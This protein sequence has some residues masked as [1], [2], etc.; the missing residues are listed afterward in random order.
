[1]PTESYADLRLP[2]GTIASPAVQIGSVGYGLWQNQSPAALGLIAAGIEAVRVGGALLEIGTVTKFHTLD[3]LGA[4]ETSDGLFVRELTTNLAKRVSLT[5]PLSISSGSLVADCYSKSAGDARYAAIAH[6]HAWADIT[7]KPST[8]TPSAHQSS[9]QSGGGDA[10]SGL[11][12]ATARVLVRRNTGTNVGPRR[13]LNF[14]EG[15]N[16]TLT[17]TDDSA[18]EEVDV[19]IA[20]TPGGGGGN[21]STTGGAAG[22]VARF[23]GTNDI[24]NARIADTL[25]GPIVFGAAVSIPGATLT[26]QAPATAGAYIGVFTSDPTTSGAAL[27]SRTLALFKG[28]LGTMPPSAHTHLWADITDKPATFPPSTH[29]HAWADITGKPSTFAPSAHQSSHQSGGGD[30]LTGLL[31]ATARVLVRRNTGTNVG[32][33]RRLNFIEGSNVTLTVAADSGQEE[34]KVTIAAAT[35]GG[36]GFVL[37][38]ARFQ[39]KNP[40]ADGVTIVGSAGNATNRFIPTTGSGTLFFTRDATVRS[41]AVYK[42]VFT[43]ASGATWA[44]SILPSY[45]TFS[46]FTYLAPTNALVPNIRRDQST[47][48][49]LHFSI[50][51]PADGAWD[52]LPKWIEIVVFSV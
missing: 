36:S 30:A 40:D 22:Q 33:H 12:D 32:P 1:M 42:Y 18:G 5:A 27:G 45:E 23:T 34:V 14:I 46:G 9:H 25:S 7:G 52:Y 10:L 15:S 44:A 35:G 51:S 38:A 26:L 41:P 43:N 3:L 2:P 49:E 20:A 6:T 11:L 50:G 48:T 28:D 29:S 24:S 21:V 47:S 4:A 17:V 16:V 39:I 13:R 37:A 19:T 31:D 8:F